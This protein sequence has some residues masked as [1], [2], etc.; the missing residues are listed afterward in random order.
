MNFSV[1]KKSVNRVCYSLNSD[2]KTLLEVSRGGENEEEETSVRKVEK[3][4]REER[5]NSREIVKRKGV[6]VF[7]GDLVERSA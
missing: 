3:G 4:V 1:A 5:G 7:W 6:D 2:G